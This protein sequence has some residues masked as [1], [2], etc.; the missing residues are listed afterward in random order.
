MGSNWIIDFA[1]K[2]ILIDTKDY[3]T[4]QISIYTGLYGI[5]SYCIW[6]MAPD[7]TKHLGAGLSF[8]ITIHEATDI[9]FNET[10]VIKSAL[11]DVTKKKFRVYAESAI[12]T[13]LSKIIKSIP[14]RVWAS[15][16]RQPISGKEIIK[17]VVEEA[18]G[19]SV[20][21]DSVS[22]KLI[23]LVKYV[24][25]SFDRTFTV[26]DLI[27]KI[28]KENRWEWYLR[29]DLLLLGNALVV[30]NFELEYAPDEWFYFKNIR[31]INTT[32]ASMRI[33]VCEPGY[34]YQNRSRLIWVQFNI[35][36]KIGDQMTFMAWNH[37][38]DY[39]KEET[40]ISTLPEGVARNLGRARMLKNLNQ[41][42]IIIG[43]MFGDISA[44]NVQ[45]YEARTF[46]A[47]VRN[48]TNDLNTHE[49]TTKYVG[50]QHMRRGAENV[51]ISTPYA[52]DG[53]GVLYPQQES[54]AVLFSP[55][56]SREM[57]IVGPRYYGV[58][59]AVPLRSN[60]QDYRLQLPAAVIYIKEDGEIII[61]QN[62]DATAVP[63]GTNAS[64]K[65]AS[66][67]T[68]SIDGVKTLLEG[69]GYTLSH[70]NHTH[71]Y[72]HIH[73]AGNLG[74]TIPPQNHIGPGLDTDSH[75]PTQ[76]TTNTEGD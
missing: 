42:P 67:G 31:T 44:E 15:N 61:E 49:F 24:A 11:F 5:P 22:T 45:K 2:Q 7:K 40:F 73:G 35:G 13:H 57:P 55:D 29:G 8:N 76:G 17:A 16:R 47:D 46:G 6:Y 20:V 68:I 64:I 23:D 38:G 21:V 52:G 37:V 54:N 34:R 14:A 69:G 53:V 3:L 30:P 48:R 41:D 43:K 26:M 9:S 75:L 18:T 74:I 63:N 36:G 12:H 19:G 4:D 28:C 25:V 66:D 70:S 72:Q 59:E 62:S 56:G 39:L 71:G 33:K 51:K 27:T 50:K 60:A 1:D 58:N 65:I 10:F 32:S